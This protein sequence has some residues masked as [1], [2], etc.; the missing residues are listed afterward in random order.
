MKC[1]HYSEVYKISC[2]ITN[3]FSMYEICLE[4]MPYIMSR[5]ILYKTNN[6]VM[7]KVKV[8]LPLIKLMN[9]EKS[10]YTNTF[11]K[12]DPAGINEEMS[13]KSEVVEMLDIKY[14]TL[15]SKNI[16]SIR[17]KTG[18]NPFIIDLNLFSLMIAKK[19]K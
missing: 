9:K 19:S 17:S 7:V 18:I 10:L 13:D 1:R 4:T 14:L 11:D 8:M 2:G 5:N 3:Y 16:T 15:K 12:K 6:F